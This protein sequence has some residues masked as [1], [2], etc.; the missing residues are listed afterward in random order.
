MNYTLK[1]LQD[2][3]N[4]LIQHLGEESP[5]AAWIYT[6]EDCYRWDENDDQVYPCEKNPELAKRILAKVNNI[7]HIHEVIQDCVEDVTE[8]QYMLLQQELV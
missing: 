8:E 5:C 6:P 4:N 2:S 7:D 3:V 1:Q